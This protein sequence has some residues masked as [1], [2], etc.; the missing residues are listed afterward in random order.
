MLVFGCAASQASDLISG[1]GQAGSGSI[2]MATAGASAAAGQ[3][4]R[5][6]ADFQEAAPTAIDT[7]QPPSK[8]IG[9]GLAFFGSSIAASG[10]VFCE[11]L[12]KKT[13]HDKFEDC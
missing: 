9:V 1:R 8:L 2:H 3:L 5:A 7:P 13:T 10:N 11:Y 4:S 12:V 6:V